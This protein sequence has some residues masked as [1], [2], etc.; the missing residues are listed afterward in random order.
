MKNTRTLTDELRLHPAGTAAPI[1]GGEFVLY[2]IQT[3]M[4]AHANHALNF[5]VEQANHL[6]LPVLVYQ[7]L[8]SDY[9][10]ASDRLHTFILE[11]AIDLQ[12]D[13]D[14]RG[15]QYSF[16][17]E[18]AGSRGPISPLVELARRA[19]LVVTDFIPTFI[20]P[21]QIRGLSTRVATPVIGVDSATMVPLRYFDR[22]HATA[23]SIR[24]RLAEALSHYLHPVPDVEPRVRRVI[25]IP[26][27]PLRVTTADVAPLVAAC[28]IDHSVPPAPSLRGG[29]RAGLRRLKAFMA[30]GLRDY[31]ALR[32]DPNVAVTSR[33]SPY[34]HFGNL[35]INE[36]LLSVRAAAPAAEY[37]RFQD[38]ALV[39]RELA[40]NFV[41]HEA[42][43]RT[44]AAVP[45]WA[46]QELENHGDDP[47]PALY[48]DAQLEAGETHDELW[49]ACQR[50]L[51]EEGELHN[52]VRMLWGKAVIAW[53]ERPADALRVLEHLNHKYALDGRDPNSYG[54]ILWCFGK[55]DRP[56]YRRPIYGLVRYMSTNGARK[57]FDVARYINRHRAPATSPA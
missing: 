23:R 14:R 38:E 48:S 16:Y 9:P 55:F 50:A 32:S 36:V 2:W 34:L 37:D 6:G 56:F 13:F 22:A 27:E 18:T 11:S 49:N 29:R 12:A 26:F 35:S 24:P 44:M 40:H 28:D 45:G 3:S 1:A 43:H 53:K 8:R 25:D 41:F 39:W 10:W 31:T 20:V 47:R 57:R 30:T 19:A 42:R 7:G 54:G 4:R 52:Y 21:R 17:L 51:V 46:R 15:I 33:L 5:A